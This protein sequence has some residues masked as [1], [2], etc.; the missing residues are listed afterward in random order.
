M[1]R[2][3]AHYVPQR[4]ALLFGAESLLML[5]AAYV[6]SAFHAGLHSDTITIPLQQLVILPLLIVIAMT[7][8]GFYQLNMRDEA[9]VIPVRAAAALLAGSLV[10]VLV[11]QVVPAFSTH[12]D[13]I[14]VTIV[15]ILL[16]VTLA[17][18]AHIRW[19][20]SSALQERL[21]VLGTGSRAAIIKDCAKRSHSYEVVRYVA[22]Q[23]CEHFVPIANLL[24]LA[25]GDSLLS[26][27]QRLKIDRI[28]IAIRDRRDGSLPIRELLQCRLAGVKVTE[29][30]TFLEREHRQVFLESISPGWLVF[31]DGFRFGRSRAVL[32]RVFDL[33][34]S[35][36]LLVLAL[37]V[38]IL[39][40]LCIILESVGPVLY[41]QERVGQG[42]RVFTI[43][44]FRSMRNDAE[45]D[46]T[47]RWADANDDRT[48]RIGR[49]IRK[50]RI[51]ELPQIINVVK[52]DMSF[53]GPRPERPFFVD[54]L[55]TQIPYYALRHGIKPGITGWAQVS[56]PYGASLDDTIQKLQYDLYYLK[57]HGLFLDFMILLATVEVVLWGKGA[58]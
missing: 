56:Y 30:P 55:V 47:P 26:V 58:R 46:G 22:L 16:S 6:G 45:R 50:L 38:M 39:A 18:F 51:D 44:K 31:G 37:P 21:L 57:N 41:R 12:P 14:I 10:G 27:V 24:T 7:S 8:M 36:V 43:Y 5:L 42:G 25:P 28:V 33:A 20:D 15:V 9:P 3:F 29:L 40:A 35:L 23:P 19:Y 1:I 49:I 34:A 53:V 4:T 32:K 48:T 2:L 11:Y 17:R 52:G 54:K 13:A